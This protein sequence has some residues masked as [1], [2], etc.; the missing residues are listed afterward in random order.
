M[1]GFVGIFTAHAADAPERGLLERMTS[2][3]T[4]RGPDSQTVMSESGVGFGFCRLAIIDLAGG[5]QPIHNEDR[6]LT[7]VCNGEIY[8]YQEL[9][10]G[11]R[12][13]GHQFRSNVDVEVLVHLYEEHE[14]GRA[15][16]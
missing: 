15:H 10:A 14:I 2:A 5:E 1:C 6:S 11:L 16:V 12:Q 13:R 7:L 8:N 4:H 9:R 3:L